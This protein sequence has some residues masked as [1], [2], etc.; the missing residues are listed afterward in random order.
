LINAKNISLRIPTQQKF[1]EFIQK[2]P[3]QM[4]KSKI[5]G[6]ANPARVSDVN[7]IGDYAAID[8]QV[9]N[10]EY[11]GGMNTRPAG[12]LKATSWLVLTLLVAG[13]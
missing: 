9:P 1:G 3:I 8:D 2:S 6:P 4:A 13:I 10:C 5:Y 11:P 12:G 7:I